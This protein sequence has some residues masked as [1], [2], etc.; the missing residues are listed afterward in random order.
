M[1]VC[2]YGLCESDGEEE[3]FFDGRFSLM[4]TLD[5]KRYAN[6]KD[7]KNL[8]KK[9]TVK[10]HSL[11]GIAESIFAKEKIGLIKL[12]V[13]GIEERVLQGAKATLQKHRSDIIFEANR[14]GDFEKCE[15]ILKPM[16]YRF[17]LLDRNN[18]LG[19]LKKPQKK[20]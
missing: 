1:K 6:R 16:G 20:D 18:W 8:K 4:A 10:V 17:R 13:E 14:E 11:D 7:L 12:D 9:G 5:G 3:L 15:R 19:Y 2:G